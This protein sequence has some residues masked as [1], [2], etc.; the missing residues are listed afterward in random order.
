[1]ARCK[2]FEALVPASAV[3]AVEIEPDKNV[4]VR[5]GQGTKHPHASDGASA[6]SGAVEVALCLVCP[7]APRIEPREASTRVLVRLDGA[8][9]PGDGEVIR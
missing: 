1:M 9:A 6:N 8:R 2:F 3:A 5:L 7:A 4:S